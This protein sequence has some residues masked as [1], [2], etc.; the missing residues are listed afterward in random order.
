MSLRELRRAEVFESSEEADAE[1][2]RRSKMLELSYRAGEETVAAISG[3]RSEGAAAPQR[4]E[5]LQSSEAREIPA[6]SAAAGAGEVFGRGTGAVWTDVGSRTFRERGWAEGGRGDAATV[7]DGGGIVE[8]DAPTESAPEKAG[9]G[10]PIL[11]TWSD[12]W[13]FPWVV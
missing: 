5:K 10:G 12:G 2:G 7:D 8:P 13:E 3:R 11:G 4:G 1:A 9:N 6:E